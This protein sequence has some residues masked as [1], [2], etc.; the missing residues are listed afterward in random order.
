[1][2][3]RL[4]VSN[5]IVAAGAILLTGFSASGGAD[6]EWEYGLAIYGWLPGI[7]GDLRYSPSSGG[8]DIDVDAEKIIDNLKMTFMGSLE[9]RKGRWSGFTDA[10]YLD[11]G[12]EKSKSVTVADGT[13]HTLYDGELDLKIKPM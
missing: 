9:A 6:E 11:L 5:K 2:G 7:T 13:T 8:D 3:A 12:G 1:M 4:G 10:I